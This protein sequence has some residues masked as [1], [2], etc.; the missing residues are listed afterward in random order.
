MIEIIIKWIEYYKKGN[1]PKNI[2]MFPDGQIYKEKWISWYDWLGNQERD[3]INVIEQTILEI[4]KFIKI[5]GHSFIKEKYET[6]DGFKLGQACK[7]IRR[8]N[9][10]SDYSGKIS[11]I[12][13]WAWDIEEEKFSKCFDIRFH[14][15]TFFFFWRSFGV[16]F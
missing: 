2:P 10:Y 6:E 9:A 13:G 5:N 16:F 8:Q 15:W 14:Y 11:K 3:P 7:M 4:E 12:K 1:V